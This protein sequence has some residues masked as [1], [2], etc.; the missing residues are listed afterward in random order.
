MKGTLR[1]PL[2][3]LAVVGAAALGSLALVTA[4]QV[5]EQASGPARIPSDSEI[6]KVLAER[7]DTYRQGV[8]MVVG[9]IEPQGRRIV[10]YGT[11]DQ[12][13]PRPVTSD[14]VFEIG[15]ITK[16][17]TSL[18]F[19]DMVRRGEVALTDP[20]IKYLPRGVKVPERNGRQ[21][22]LVD[23]ATHTSALPREALNFEPTWEEWEFGYSEDALYEFLGSYQLTEDIGSEHEYSNLG[24]SLL[25]IALARRAEM[26]YEALVRARIGEPLGLDSTGWSLTSS[27]KARLAMGHVYT[28]HPA[29][30]TNL[31]LFAGS[32]GLRS[33]AN[34][35]LLLLG[36]Q[37]GYQQTPLAPAMAAMLDVKFNLMPPVVRIFKRGQFQHLGW[38]ETNGL[39]W[40][41]GGTP[42]YRSFI[43]FDPKRRSGVV[44]LS[45][46]AVDTGVDDIGMHL[47]NQKMPLLGSRELVPAK[48]HRE[49]SVKAELLDRYVGRYGFSSSDWITVTRIENQLW[50]GGSGYPRVRFYPE[51]ETSFFSKTFN[52]Q[53]VFAVDREGRAT[54]AVSSRSGETKRYKRV[55]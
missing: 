24:V 27:M 44:V 43:G 40:H 13:N 18:V 35:L 55:Q 6:R 54:E 45:N 42:G 36:A 37:L 9:L 31:R 14:T 8:G 47:L 19:A 12:A 33:T 28:L 30:N 32:G 52:E 3:A 48:A 41:S 16:V 4:A 51:S 1:S 53:I 11:L 21:I 5:L 25:A 46:A 10:S 17:F 22:T 26:D 29:P 38:F 49:I 2:V 50:V 20:V 7:I 39:I 34:D 23:L 15:S